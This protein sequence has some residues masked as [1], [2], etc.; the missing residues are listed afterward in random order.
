MAIRGHFLAFKPKVDVNCRGLNFGFICYFNA[1][2]FFV[3]AKIWSVWRSW[4]GVAPYFNLRL[5]LIPVD[6]KFT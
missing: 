3:R 4:N 6:V 2:Y 1:L 5:C